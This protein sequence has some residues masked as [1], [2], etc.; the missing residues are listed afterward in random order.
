MSN[1][2]PIAPVPTPKP[3]TTQQ[4]PPPPMPPPCKPAPLPPPTHRQFSAGDVDKPALDREAHPPVHAPPPPIPS[5]SVE[6]TGVRRCKAISASGQRCRVEGRW[7][8]GFCKAHDPARREEVREEARRGRE[9][10]LRSRLR[11]RGA[12]PEAEVQAYMERIR[13]VTGNPESLAAALDW[14]AEALLRGTI[15]APVARQLRIAAGR[16]Q[17]ILAS[18][19]HPRIRHKSYAVSVPPGE[20]EPALPPI[21]P[22]SAIAAP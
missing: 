8:S 11:K 10:A 19:S 6:D 7:A 1:D 2:Q 21:V 14:I 12:I 5:Q 15:P 3:C 22:P 13:A 20:P 16:R 9:N 4:A 17:R 18:Y